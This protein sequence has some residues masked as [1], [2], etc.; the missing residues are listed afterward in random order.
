ERNMTELHRVSGK[1]VWLGKDLARTQEHV[2]LFPRDT[3]TEID[4][5][6]NRIRQSGKPLEEIGVEDFPFASM[7]AKLKACKDELAT[8]RGL[9]IM[10]GIP[11]EKYTDD[12]L[13]M[14]FWGFGAHFGVQMPQSFL[15][16]RLGTVMDLTDEEPERTKRR[17]YHSAGAQT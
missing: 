4:E 10:R 14:I 16:D 1:S 15:G 9:V 8:G 17:G 3:L 6:V 7:G 5:C 11:A 12:E 13:G 2:Q